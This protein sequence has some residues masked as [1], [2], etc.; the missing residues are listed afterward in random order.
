M[1]T[2]SFYFV[3]L[4]GGVL[5][6]VGLGVWAMGKAASALAEVRGLRDE[7]ARRA[8][9]AAHEHQ[10]QLEV[11]RRQVADL[12]SGRALQRDM[13]LEGRL[14]GDMSTAQAVSVHAAGT[15]R[16]LDVRT[17]SETS[18]G[19]IPGALV[20]PVEQL[21]ERWREVPRDGKALIVYCASGGRSA[22]A[23]EFLASKGFDSLTNLEAGYSGWNGP[24]AKP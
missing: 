7:L 13:V 1:E 3:V 16:F 12:A 22:A 6:A 11:L 4:A 20:I 17:P 21:E 18:M 23:C 8:N 15:A 14:W 5:V 10:A 24:R 2:A 19:V 9:N